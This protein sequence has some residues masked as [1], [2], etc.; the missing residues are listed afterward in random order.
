MEGL[1]A[2]IDHVAVYPDDIRLMGLTQA[3]QLRTLELVMSRLEG[4]WL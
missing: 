3:Q 4:A 2:G 1:L